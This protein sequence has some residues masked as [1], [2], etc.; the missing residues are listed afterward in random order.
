M[1]YVLDERGSPVAATLVAA[2]H[3]GRGSARAALDFLPGARFTPG[4][5]AGCAAPV[6]VR[7]PFT[8]RLEP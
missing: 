1:T 3:T 4:R 2:H 6:L 5:V 7:Q 8:F